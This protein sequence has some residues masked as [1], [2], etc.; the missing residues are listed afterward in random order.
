[1]A[2]SA[3]WGYGRLPCGV[4][5][6]PKIPMTRSAMGEA[7][8]PMEGGAQARPNIAYR[9]VSWTGQALRLPFQAPAV[10]QPAV[11][12]ENRVPLNAALPDLITAL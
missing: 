12:M 1:M 3:A 6:S 9:K 10:F 7:S 8:F 4:R 11:D 2:V 5:T